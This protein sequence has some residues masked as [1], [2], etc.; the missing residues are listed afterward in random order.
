MSKLTLVLSLLALGAFGIAACGDDDDEETTPAQTTTEKK[1][2][3][4]DG[5]GA[6][7]KVSVSAA[8]D[9]SL[10]FEEKDLKVDAGEVTFEFDNPAQLPHDYCVEDADGD[11]VGCTDQIT[12]GEDSL[13]VDLK[14]GKYEFY[15]SVAGH[16]E[17][18]MEGP[19][20]V[21]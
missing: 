7:E 10:A 1:T 2:P 14:P 19:L 11:E 3:A 17:G 16:R 18:G 8:P 21:K 15:C 13:T 12:D 4:G 20:T 9:G 5:G 6:A